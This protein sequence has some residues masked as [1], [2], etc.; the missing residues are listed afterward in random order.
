MAFLD[1]WNSHSVSCWVF[2]AFFEGLLFWF[3]DLPSHP[4]PVY[5]LLGKGAPLIKI[6]HRR[7]KSFGDWQQILN[8]LEFKVWRI[9]IWICPG[10]SFS[11]AHSMFCD[12]RFLQKI[13]MIYILKLNIS[14]R[15]GG[16]TV[17][18]QP[19]DILPNCP[20]LECLLRGGPKPNLRICGH[21][22]KA[23]GRHFFSFVRHLRTC[24]YEW[25]YNLFNVIL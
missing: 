7:N 11:S 21:D 14:G 8:N 15:S 19:E 9:Y 16:P 3:S 17:H 2:G 25:L 23:Q 5:W 10:I 20:T 6:G 22:F 12:G 1:L 18:R 13:F 24:D 4:S